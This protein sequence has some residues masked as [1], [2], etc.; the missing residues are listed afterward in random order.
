MEFGSFSLLNA[1]FRPLFQLLIIVILEKAM[2]FRVPVPDE[3]CVLVTITVFR[4][5][6]N[7]LNYWKD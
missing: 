3:E 7:A 4:V 5:G 2:V 1:V 6:A